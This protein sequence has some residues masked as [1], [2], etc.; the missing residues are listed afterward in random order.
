MRGEA[1]RVEDY[2]GW[3][4]IREGKQEPMEDSA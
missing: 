4:L 3:V 2:D 1:R